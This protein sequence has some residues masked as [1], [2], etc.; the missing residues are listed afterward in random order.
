MSIDIAAV[1]IGVLIGA[2]ASIP[3]N[4]I[5]AFIAKRLQA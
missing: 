3:M 1:A 2:L 5:I 4:V